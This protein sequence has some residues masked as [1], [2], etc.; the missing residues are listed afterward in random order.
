MITRGKK[1]CFNRLCLINKSLVI[2]SSNEILL[3]DLV[4]VSHSCWP[5]N[6]KVSGWTIHNY[7][8]DSQKL[9]KV[10]GSWMV[11]T[12]V[13]CIRELAPWKWALETRWATWFVVKVPVISNSL[14]NQPPSLPSPCNM[15]WYETLHVYIGSSDF[16]VVNMQNNK[17]E[18]TSQW[19]ASHQV[20]TRN[21]L[22]PKLL[23]DALKRIVLSSTVNFIILLPLWQ[24]ASKLHDGAVTVKR[25]IKNNF[26]DGSKQEA[27]DILLLGNIFAGPAGDRARALLRR[28]FLHCKFVFISVFIGSWLNSSLLST[29]T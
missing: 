25:T 27:I 22:I 2:K 6:W 23:R 20:W 24:F 16:A 26:F 10:C 15:L 14:R 8:L 3:C 21:I 28:T 29:T 12:S 5:S 4:F 17:W 11:T 1:N 9:S 19:E 13:A 7:C 18:V